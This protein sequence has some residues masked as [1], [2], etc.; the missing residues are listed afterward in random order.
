MIRL[1]DKV[2]IYTLMVRSMKVNGKKTNKTD[3]ERKLGPTAL[4]TKEITNKER[5]QDMVNLSGLTDL[6][7]IFMEKVNFR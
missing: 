3:K 5:S 4:V 1:M 7:I 6:R 2:F